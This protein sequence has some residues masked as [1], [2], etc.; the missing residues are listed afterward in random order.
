MLNY[1]QSGA[2]GGAAGGAPGELPRLRLRLRG[3]P[4]RDALRWGGV[5][6][7]AHRGPPGGG[8]GRREPQSAGSEGWVGGW[9]RERR[10]AVRAVPASSRTG[11]WGSSL[12]YLAPYS[13]AQQPFRP[14][15]SLPSMAC[16][17]LAT[18]D[19]YH[20]VTRKISNDVVLAKLGTVIPP[21]L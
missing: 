20:G 11:H 16:A 15:L 9:L 6:C 14:H 8:R 2:S 12:L 17:E 18:Q 19:G 4:L 3:G 21:F 7:R 5:P 10:P 1:P 13:R